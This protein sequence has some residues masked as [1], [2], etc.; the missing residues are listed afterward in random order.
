MRQALESQHEERVADREAAVAKDAAAGA[1]T[2]GVTAATGI[3]GYDLIGDEDEDDPEEDREALAKAEAVAFRRFAKARR[4]AGK[5]R[6]F[7]FRSVDPVRARRLNQAGRAQVRKDAGEVAVAGLAV[8]AA[9]TGRVLMLQRALDPEDP[10]A[11]FWEMPGGHLEDGETPLRGAW[12]EWAEETGLIPPPGAATGTW[13]SADGV[14]EGIVWTVDSEDAVPINGDRDQITNPDDPDGDAVEAIAWWDPAQLAGN[15]AVR[16]E[17]LASLPDV[18]AALGIESDD[19]AGELA[20]AAAGKGDAPAKGAHWPGWEADLQ[21]AHYWAEVLAGALAGTLTQRRAELLAAAYLAQQPPPEGEPDKDALTDAALV[22]LAAQGLDLVTPVAG[23]LP[24][25]WTD[26]YLVGLTSAHAAT[27]GKRAQ[28]GG[29]QPGDTETAQQLVADSGGADGLAE[30][31]DEAPVAA[32]GIAETRRRDLARELVKGLL[33]GAA[34]SVIGRALVDV[35]GSV[36]SALTVTVTEITRS[37]GLAALY[38]YQQ[39]G[40]SQVRW[41]AEADGRV[42]PACLRNAASD[43]R[44]VGAAFPSGDSHP[45]IHPRCRCAVVP[46]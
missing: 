13:E 2:A 6:D 34:A 7:E 11:G 40:V 9:D 16:P 21:A 42:C 44:P 45:P 8:H 18:L 23:V 43:S 24:G 12:R 20:K 29:W 22:W 36:S 4:R 5:W 28:R 41:A 30:V 32:E 35:L 39:L 38:G 14:Y 17:L 27:T 31:V 19:D 33:A 37:S 1:P 25:L 10:A 46:A 26:G 15:P 3:T